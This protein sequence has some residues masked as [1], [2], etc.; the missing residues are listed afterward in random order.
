MV[1]LLVMLFVFSGCE[2]TAKALSTT[3]SGTVT[4]EDG[5]PV[6]GALILV[7]EYDPTN[8]LSIIS[9]A[10]LE[11]VSISLADGRYTVVEVEPG[12][13]MVF[14]VKDNGN[15]SVDLT[16]DE[17]Y[18]YGTSFLG[19]PNPSVVTVENK[20]DDVTDIVINKKLMP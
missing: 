11:S 2:E 16:E 19:I 3:I 9:G 4:T 15:L 1:F 6:Q 17:I 18:F 7:M 20:H 13:Y 12:D 10:S 8:F 14:A 5:E